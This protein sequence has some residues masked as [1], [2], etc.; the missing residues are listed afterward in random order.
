[1]ERVAEAPERQRAEL[2]QAARRIWEAYFPLPELWDVAF[3]LGVLLLAVAR[4]AEA[5]DLF[6]CSLGLYGPEPAT[7]FNLALCHHLLGERQEA[8]Q[9]IDRALAADPEFPG[10]AALRQ[11]I[12]ESSPGAELKRNHS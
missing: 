1:M 7:L 8:L 4:P 3:H 2:A 10:A 12:E 11:E 6:G 9:G 5:A